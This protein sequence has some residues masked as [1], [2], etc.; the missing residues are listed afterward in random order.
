MYDDY[1]RFKQKPFSIAPDPAFL[2]LSERHREAL[3]H[4][5]YGLRTDGGF[6]LI[7]GEVGTGKTTLIRSLIDEVPDDIDVA[8]VLNPRLTV[9]ELLE[10]LCEELGIH[11]RSEAATTNKHLIDRLNKHLLRT[12]ALGRSTVV[13]IDEAQNLSP[14]VLEQIRLLTNL[15]TNERKLV[16]IILLGQPEL[17]EMLDRREM[18]QLV[19]RVT[20]RYHLAALTSDDTRAYIA[21][22]L[23]L[24]GGNPH[25]FT[26]G[27]ARETFRLSRG[28]P[29]LINVIAD[30]ALLGTYV[31]GRPRVSARIVRKAAREAFGQQAWLRPRLWTGLAASLLLLVIA[32]AW[33]LWDRN[34]Q[35]RTTPTASPEHPAVSETVA[36]PPD[37]ASNP[38]DSVAGRSESPAGS[39]GPLTQTQATPDDIAPTIKPP[40]IEPAPAVADRFARPAGISAFD[41]QRDAYAAVFDRWGAAFDP[42]AVP[43]DQAP[44][45]GLQCLKQNGTW[46]DIERL[47]QPVVLELWDDSAKPYYAALLRHSDD[48]MTVKL[49]GTEIETTAEEL[50]NHWY[51]SYVVLWQMPPDYRG[52]LE[53]GDQGPSV[54]WLRQHLASAL[55]IDL[56]APDPARFDDGLRTA[57]IRFQ[58]E[59]GMVPDGVA[60]PMTWIAVNSVTSDAT[61]RLSVG[62]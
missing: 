35:W 21:H 12:H 13:I 3:A 50:G 5:M 8:F 10:T 62:S 17:A 31:E 20:A 6:V 16:R 45:A 51:G 40:T 54:A 28:I 58:R 48:T 30:R 27:A 9:N 22:R 33:A 26:R 60:G 11:P 4:L 37:V 7:T 18:R 36:R 46:N 61:P 38:S 43:C 49:G 56:R 29:R 53:L 24:A 52:N 23:S 1:Y 15:E 44:D 41:S 57:L 55:Q 14:A 42:T 59:N 47:D 25:L 19:Q 39:N 34:P 2:Y 32:G